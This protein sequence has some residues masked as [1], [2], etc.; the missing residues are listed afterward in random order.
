[1]VMNWAQVHLWL[2]HLPILGVLCGLIPVLLLY[3]SDRN[4][5]AG[6]VVTFA[7]PSLFSLYFMLLFG[8]SL[9]RQHAFLDCYRR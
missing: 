9:N 3:I 6:L 4:I 7:F 8:S 1:M 2:N 5:G